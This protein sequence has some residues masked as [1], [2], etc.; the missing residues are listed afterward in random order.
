[1]CTHIADLTRD[2]LSRLAWAARLI[3]GDWLETAPARASAA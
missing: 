1:M 2:F 3:W